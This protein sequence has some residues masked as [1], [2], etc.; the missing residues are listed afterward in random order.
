VAQTDPTHVGPGDTDN[1]SNLN[2]DL[3]SALK[4]G[5]TPDYTNPVF[6][7]GLMALG[8]DAADV[9]Y[10][11]ST[12]DSGQDGGGP[13]QA[14]PRSAVAPGLR[15][16]QVPVSD[17]ATGPLSFAKVRHGLDFFKAVNATNGSNAQD[18]TYLYHQ[19]TLPGQCA[20]NVVP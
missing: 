1:A 10:S 9:L 19:A 11:A 8:F 12:T 20:P 14:L 2:G 18:V 16:P 15:C 17:G 4:L 6:A 5:T 3:Q 13:E 7:N